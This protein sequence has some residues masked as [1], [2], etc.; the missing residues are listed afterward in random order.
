MTMNVH[1]IVCPESPRVPNSAVSGG[2]DERWDVTATKINGRLSFAKA[3]G[4]WWESLNCQ[5]TRIAAGDG[6]IADLM[7]PYCAH[8]PGSGHEKILSDDALAHVDKVGMALLGRT[9]PGMYEGAT[10]SSM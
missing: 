2:S 7:S 8:Y 4:P 3:S 5:L 1:S 10:G 9:D 6:T